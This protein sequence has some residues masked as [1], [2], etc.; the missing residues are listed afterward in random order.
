MYLLISLVILG[1][2]TLLFSR[3]AGSLA[4]TRINMIAWIFY[5]ELVAQSFIASVLVINGWDNH[6]I[7]GRVQ[8][9]ARFSGW[10]AVQYT[11]VAMPLGMLLVVYLGGATSNR[12]LFQRYLNLPIESFLSQRDSFIR[13]PLYAL[14]AISLLAVLYTF[15]SLGE[16]P[17]WSAIK[18]GDAVSLAVSR[19]DASLGFTGNVYV[20]NLLGI[21]LT[22]ILTYVAFGYFVQTGDLTDRLWFYAML[23]ASFFMLTYDL[24]K[25]PIVIFALGFL[26]FRVLAQ[27]GVSRLMFYWFGCIAFL[28]LV[29]SYWLVGKV[30]DP[31]MFF[32]YN[33]GI[34]GRILLSQ[35][36]GTYFAFEHFPATHQFLGWTSLSSF[37]SEVAGLP[38][39]D[40]AARIMMMIFN[41][42]G[43]EEG[44]VAVMNSLFIAEA[45]ANFGLVGV[46]VAPIYVGVF[47]QL[48]FQFFL[49]SKKTPLFLG[50]FAYLSLRLPVTGGFN[51][52]VYAPG[53]ANI[54]FLFGSIYLLAV[55]LKA[56]TRKVRT[57]RLVVADA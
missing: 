7:I 15:N 23:A 44:S 18:G 27:G 3:V 42:S 2:S 43:V 33:S 13:L 39:S 35:A 10:L 53:L 38:R 52:F 16:V 14:S 29:A 41:P 47:I 11:M 48:L 45:W 46:L 37:I 1:I 34:A 32:S 50:V 21:T 6:Y 24:S 36:A 54:A 55:L 8:S 4:P 9:D 20:R 28:M 22:P 56:V 19:V 31:A 57:G 40:R 26:V 12:A 51:D 17:L 49:R 30:T 5:F 25:A